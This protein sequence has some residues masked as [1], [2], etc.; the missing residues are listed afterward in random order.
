MKKIILAVIAALV[1]VGAAD[2]QCPEDMQIS[3]VDDFRAAYEPCKKA[4]ESGGADLPA[5]LKCLKYYAK[6]RGDCWPCICMVAKAEK[7]HVQGCD[8]YEQ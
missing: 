8:Q 5:T 1:T 7:I 2:D 6:M 4:A 3:C